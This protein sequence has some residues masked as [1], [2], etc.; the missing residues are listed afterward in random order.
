[1]VVD[2]RFHLKP[3]LPLL[4]GDGRFFVLA[5]SQKQ[6]RL[7]EGSM[8]RI[9]ELDLHSVPQRLQDAVGYDWQERF[10]QFHT[11]SAR[12]SAIF[13][14]HGAGDDQ[15]AEV[16]KFLR[17]VDRALL[18]LLRDKQVPLV[19]AAAEPILSMYREISKH[20]HLADT[21][22]PGSPDQ[23]SAEQLHGQAWQLVEP[24]FLAQRRAWADRYA[25]LAGTG[26]ATDRLL[27]I[28]PAVFDGRVETLFIA[29]DQERWGRYD[30]EARQAT[31]VQE[32]SPG[33]HEL[34]D[35]AAVEALN[36]GASVYAVPA[37]RLP[38]DNGTGIAAIFR[39]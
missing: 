18:E 10:L 4:V 14:G 9:R 17:A 37:D 22:I 8:T 28:L 33:D 25:E 2:D 12:S 39:Y 23:L 36:R 5:L 16:E 26:R 34:L 1:V 21:G 35:L 38:T 19:I 32:P 13:H 11:A 6:V 3:L 30:P 24:G 27:D 7:M 20:P 15:K 31:L 29:T